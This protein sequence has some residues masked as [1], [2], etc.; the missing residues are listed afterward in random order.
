MHGRM[1]TLHLSQV[2]NPQSGS[3]RR[4]GRGQVPQRDIDINAILMDPELAEAAQTVSLALVEAEATA[5]RKA[6]GL[7]DYPDPRLLDYL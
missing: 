4:C 1:S 6:N 2:A 5:N 7:P 3:F